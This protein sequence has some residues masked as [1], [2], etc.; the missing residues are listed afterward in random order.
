M[1]EYRDVVTS[2]LREDT[3]ILASVLAMRRVYRSALYEVYLCVY[4]G[5]LN[6]PRLHQDL[7]SCLVVFRKESLRAMCKLW[8]DEIEG[9]RNDYIVKAVQRLE[10]DG[11]GP[12]DLVRNTKVWAHLSFTDEDRRVL[13]VD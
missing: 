12:F 11:L 8:T 5:L 1:T 6:H 9:D 2:Y 7:I 13:K 4:S 10:G 3:R